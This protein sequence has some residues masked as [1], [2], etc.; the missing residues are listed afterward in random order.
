M[1]SRGVL[2]I[3]L[4]SALNC[5]YYGEMGRLEPSTQSASPPN[6]DRP[7]GLSR[8]RYSPITYLGS[9]SSPGP[10]RWVR[11][12]QIEQAG[13]MGVGSLIRGLGFGFAR[14]ATTSL[15]QKLWSSREYTKVVYCQ[16]HEPSAIVLLNRLA[17]AGSWGHGRTADPGIGSQIY[18]VHP[19]ATRACFVQKG[20]RPSVD[21]VGTTRDSRAW[22]TGNQETSCLSVSRQSAMERKTSRPVGGSCL[23]SGFCSCGLLVGCPK[24][25]LEWNQPS[26]ITSRSHRRYLSEGTT[27]DRVNAGSEEIASRALSG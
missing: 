16:Q 4:T 17:E 8:S 22:E 27:H 1:F 3:A 15:V 14:Q 9:S 10:C 19:S 12:W 2:S 21:A 6:S 13:G 11:G 18:A 23:S 5:L 7:T 25:D 20:T 24:S 26:S